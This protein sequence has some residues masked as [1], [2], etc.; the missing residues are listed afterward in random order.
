LNLDLFLPPLIGGIVIGTA[1]SLLLLLDGRI[2][3][4]SGILGGLLSPKKN[5]FFWRL[6]AF[7][8]L[9]AAGFVLL[10][11]NP[12]YLSDQSTST[13]SRYIIA[14]LL[15]GFGT[16]LGS[17]CTSGHGV[18]GISRMSI[19]SIVATGTFIFFGMLA[20]A[21]MRYLGMTP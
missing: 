17:G 3:G 16:Q 14:G 11:L 15:V 18:C 7:L 4:V 2:F 8:G 5:E 10:K 20:V 21:A 13:S 1:T 12:V 6:A 19:R 9:V